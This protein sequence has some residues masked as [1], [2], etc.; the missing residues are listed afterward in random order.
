MRLAAAAVTAA[1]AALDG[2]DRMRLAYYYVHGLTL[3]QAGRLF[4]E[5]EATASRKLERIRRQLHTAIGGTLGAHGLAAAEVADWAEVARHAWDGALAD[6][7]GVPAPQESGPPSF[8]GK[9]TP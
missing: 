3:A 1:L 7:L 8:K 4:G 6:A 9:R 2:A 5:S